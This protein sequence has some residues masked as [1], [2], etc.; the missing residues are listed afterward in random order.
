MAWG[1]NPP[2]LH[3]CRPPAALQR[4][5]YLP[6]KVPAAPR[7][8]DRVEQR[9]EG[10]EG[11]KVMGLVEDRAGVHRTG[12]VQEEDAKSRQPANNEDT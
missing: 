9:V 11:K 1:P 10:C 3:P 7:V 4:P 2:S 8:N 12:I 5:Q 6:P